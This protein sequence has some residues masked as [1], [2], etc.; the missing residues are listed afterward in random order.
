MM[1]QSGGHSPNCW[2]DDW[3]RGSIPLQRSFYQVSAPQ[4]SQIT[5]RE[6]LCNGKLPFSLSTPTKISTKWHRQ[7]SKCSRFL[8]G[9]NIVIQ[10]RLERRRLSRH[11]GGPTLVVQVVRQL[12]VDRCK[13]FAVACMRRCVKG[14]LSAS[15]RP[16]EASSRSHS[17]GGRQTEREPA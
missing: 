12:Y 11:K 4:A 2:F 16:A 10:L 15:H 5:L 17:G 1:R 7:F 3:S 8:C 6:W 13:L 9:R 14:R